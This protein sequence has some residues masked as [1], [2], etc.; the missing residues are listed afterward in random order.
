MYASISSG[1]TGE[2]SYMKIEWRARGICFARN[3]WMICHAVRGITLYIVYMGN[4]YGKPLV[5]NQSS[6][7]TRL[8]TSL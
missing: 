4:D 1:S 7:N 6:T 2:E 8:L 3:I 5:L